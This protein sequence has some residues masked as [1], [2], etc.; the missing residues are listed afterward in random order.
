MDANPKVG[1]IARVG[2]HRDL[3]GAGALHLQCESQCESRDTPFGKSNPVHIMEI[4]GIPFAPADRNCVW[5]GSFIRNAH[6]KP[7]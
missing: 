1:V 6:G 7:Q 5:M 3:E 4:E 2:A